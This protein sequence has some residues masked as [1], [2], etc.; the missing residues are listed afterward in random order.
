MRTAK[1]NASF[2]YL[3]SGAF[4][5]CDW[6]GNVKLNVKNHAMPNIVATISPEDIELNPEDQ[7]TSSTPF[8]IEISA[9]MEI[10]FDFITGKISAADLFSPSVNSSSFTI[11][12]NNKD[13]FEKFYNA[14]DFSE[15]NFRQW[16]IQQGFHPSSDSNISF[17]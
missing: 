5:G 2:H 3:I 13:T 15:S 6:E 7:F 17:R 12:P 10:L 8:V 11:L 14:F 9:T 1:L 16:K 4:K